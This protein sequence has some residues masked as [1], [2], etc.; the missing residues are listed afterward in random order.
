MQIEHVS[1]TQL[2][3]MAAPYNPRRI[4][5][6][7]LDALRRS[8]RFF[9][10]VE[11]IVV[12]KRSGH[13]VGGHQRVRAAEAEGIDTLP[14]V[15]VDLDDPS[16]RQLNLALNKISGEW[17]EEKL[18]AVLA[19]LEQVGACFPLRNPSGFEGVNR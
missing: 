1:T 3:G 6:H 15:Y 10:T 2:A 7:D 16:E 17:D 8:L 9:G 14:V 4:S 18:A 5:D 19:E 13:I 11:P 12:N